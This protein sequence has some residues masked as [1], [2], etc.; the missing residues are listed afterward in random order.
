[1]KSKPQLLVL[2][3][4]LPFPG[5]AG[6]QQRV[7]YT[8]RALRELFHVT[9][10]TFT[11]NNNADSV[12]LQMSEF[13]D[14]LVILPALYSRTRSERT[15]HRVSALVQTLRTGLKPSN[16]VIGSLEFSPSRITSYFGE[17]S[18][19]CVLFEYW[20]A[21]NSTR[22]FR[23]RG[24]PCVLDTHDILWQAYEQQIN[25][26]HLSPAVKK[27]LI[28]RYRVQEES[29]WNQFDT[30]IA[31]NREEQKYL[32]AKVAKAVEVLHA[33]MG[34]DLSL[35]PYSW[36]P[37]DVKR[38][39]YYGGLGSKRNE[40]SAL[41]CFHSIM[42]EIWRKFPDAEFWVVGSNPPKSVQA[43]A[44]DPRVKVTGFVKNVQETLGKMSAMICPWSGRF[45]FRS[46]LVETMALGIPL[47]TTEDAIFGMEL[48]SGK[49]LLT[50]SDSRELS[51]HLLALLS[52]QN[53]AR[54]QSQLGRQQVED[55]YSF[56][57][58]YQ[59]LTYELRDW[60][61]QRAQVN[62]RWPERPGD[63]VFSH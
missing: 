44:S 33:P 63:L 18:F 7:A 59:R 38:I 61:R 39:A 5:N 55:L 24:I 40:Q 27:W 42:P 11:T 6:Q 58:T 26:S 19:D 17:K 34:I 3:H 46:R 30:V 51:H 22:V 20:H 62:E 29:A 52:N 16:Y 56:E 32:R 31:I 53:L 54:E 23:E 15:R 13:C 45:G 2:S 49:G 25:G 10:G 35:W 57:A 12:R 4:V 50:G 1:M 14:E 60:L 41:D 36:E 43:L 21:A 47:V 8:L 9:F 37:R 28:N 48:E